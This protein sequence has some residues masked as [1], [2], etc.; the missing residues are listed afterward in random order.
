M[1]WSPSE[2]EPDV[3]TGLTVLVVDDS[4]FARSMISKRLS[5]DPDIGRVEA[6]RDGQEALDKLSSLKPD[7]IT[8]D[9][10]MPKLDG[11]GALKRIM[12]ECPTPVVMLSSLTGEDTETTL[13]A[14][15]LGAVDFF[16]KPS[17]ANTTGG[18]GERDLLETIKQAARVPVARLA[19]ALRPE[20]RATQKTVR[21]SAA[22]P[23]RNAGDVKK[24]ERVVVIASSTG[25]PRALAGVVPNLPADDRV[26]YLLVQH[27]PAGFTR[28]LSERLNN[29]SKLTVRE[30]EKGEFIQGG[31]ALMAPGGYH[32]VVASN[33]EI[34]LTETPTLHGVRPA[35]DVTM[36]SAARAFSKKVVGVVLTGMGADG[37]DG[38]GAIRAAGGSVIAE[39][40]ATCAVFGMPRAVIEAG[41]ANIV[42]TIDKISRQIVKTY[43]R[44]FSERAG[45]AD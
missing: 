31:T 41:H 25:G 4:A 20:V 17:I 22:T 43:Q 35:A 36:Q 10:Q 8:L 1:D 16:L 30:A 32:L 5:A 42:V 26:A 40:E 37:K 24:I 13:T 34:D 15:E 7:V 28:S 9:V 21:Q 39:D 19:K 33:G 14:L 3:N 38:A 11:L 18:D 23:T 2:Q 44:G 27:M 29:S 6:A 45:A 12:A